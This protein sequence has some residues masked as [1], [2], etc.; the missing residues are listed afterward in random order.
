MEDYKELKLQASKY[1]ISI[2]EFL[3][4]RHPYAFE[5]NG[6]I[7]AKYG[8]I[9][10]IISGV[11]QGKV[12]LGYGYPIEYW[13]SSKNRLS[14]EAW[15]DFGSIG[16]MNDQ[17]VIGMLNDIFPRFTQDAYKILKWLNT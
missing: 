13:D 16:F 7:I 3:V 9:S 12:K 17:E 14:S 15:A 10:D 8:G 1:K 4:V 6:K 2:K 5:A 11:T